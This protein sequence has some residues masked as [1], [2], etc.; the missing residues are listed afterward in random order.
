MIYRITFQLN[1]FRYVIISVVPLCFQPYE[2]ISSLNFVNYTRNPNAFFSPLANLQFR[3]ITLEA[4][5]NQLNESNRIK[6]AIS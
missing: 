1:T 3:F 5:S 4:R 2:N 6:L